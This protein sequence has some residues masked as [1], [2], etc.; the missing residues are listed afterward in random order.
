MQGWCLLETGQL[1]SAER[2]SREILEHSDEQ[3][4][5]AAVSYATHFLG[6]TL[7]MQGRLDEALEWAERGVEAF[8]VRPTVQ[9]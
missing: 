6:L 9:P 4:F 7:I 1:E 2:K 3:G 5:V 8:H